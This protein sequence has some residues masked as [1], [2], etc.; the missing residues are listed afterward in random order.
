MEMMSQQRWGDEQTGVYWHTYYCLQCTVQ[1]NLKSSDQV[2]RHPWTP[3]TP[4]LPFHFSPLNPFQNIYFEQLP[5]FVLHVEKFR[6]WQFAGWWRTLTIR[7]MTFIARDRSSPFMTGRVALYFLLNLHLKSNKKGE[8]KQS[9]WIGLRHFC[10]FHPSQ[11]MSISITP[12]VKHTQWRRGMS[13][14]LLCW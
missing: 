3:S 8:K 14:S 13:E 7:C 11:I 12:H 2:T 1:N 4:H 9:L 10:S 5:G 6:S